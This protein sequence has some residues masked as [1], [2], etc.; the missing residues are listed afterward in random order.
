MDITAN[1]T[2][3]VLLGLIALA[4]EIPKDISINEINERTLQ[5]QI[6][7]AKKSKIFKIDNNHNRIRLKS[8]DGL[9]ALQEFSEELY[10][11]Y[12]M[13]SNNHQFQTSKK[14]L[15]NQKQFSQTVLMMIENGYEIDNMNII[16]K[17]NHFGKNMEKVDEIDFVLGDGL[18]DFGMNKF[19]SSGKIIPVIDAASLIPFHEK[20]F[21]TSKYLKLGESI[22]DRINISRISGVMLS[23]GNLY[24]VYNLEDGAR[25]FKNSEMDMNNTIQNLYASAYGK[26]LKDFEA[27]IITK[28]LPLRTERL[29][30]LFSH[31]YFIPN[32]W[33]GNI[34]IRI[35]SCE[36]W[37]EKVQEA[38]YGEVSPSSIADGFFNNIPSW[39]LV[40]CEYSK[41]KKVKKIAG[42]NPVHFII[43]DWQE[44]IIKKLTQG[45]NCTYQKLLHEQELIL[46]ETVVKN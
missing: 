11:H 27:I 29:D 46:L 3:E 30:G 42:N 14:A 33:Y 37:R 36:N 35:L 34:V 12:N 23:Q 5:N 4:G 1:N 10:M 22:N 44:N 43:Y 41:I 31:Y 9:T 25:I 24:N 13:V 2:T 40:T 28:T 39:E 45:M 21:F 18:L 16:H 7:K 8:P 17:S 26:I 15:A 20:R 38:L 19:T 6:S 32:S